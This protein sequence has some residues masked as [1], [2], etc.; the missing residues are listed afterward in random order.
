MYMA[1]VGFN[2]EKDYQFHFVLKTH[3]YFYKINS[4]TN[5]TVIGMLHLKDN[6]LILFFTKSVGGGC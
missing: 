1:N 4:F 6:I 3:S 5:A 2:V